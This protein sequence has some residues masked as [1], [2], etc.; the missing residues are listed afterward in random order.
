VQSELKTYDSFQDWLNAFTPSEDDG[1]SGSSRSELSSA[2]LVP[3][4]LRK[5]DSITDTK[6]RT[7]LR[8]DL[9]G[10]DDS[11]DENRIS[12]KEVIEVDSSS[13]VPGLI[14]KLREKGA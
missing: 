13:T 6:P 1:H 14:K 12:K 8:I 5:G 4:M 11:R 9:E 10:P 2:T 7:T 3:E